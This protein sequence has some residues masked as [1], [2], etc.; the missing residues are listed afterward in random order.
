MGKKGKGAKNVE[1]LKHEYE[2]KRSDLCSDYQERWKTI[3]Q[4]TA[5]AVTQEAFSNKVALDFNN[6]TDEPEFQCDVH[7]VRNT[8][9]DDSQ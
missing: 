5:R 2:N 7:I 4:V 3:C 6:F 1:Q 8:F 9:V